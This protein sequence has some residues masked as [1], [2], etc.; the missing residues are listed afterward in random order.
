VFHQSGRTVDGVTFEVSG[1]N[2]LLSVFDGDEPPRVVLP[3]DDEPSG[4]S[5]T[6][7]LHGRW[8]D[9]SGPADLGESDDETEIAAAADD[10]DEF[11]L[12]DDLTEVNDSE[13]ATD[14]IIRPSGGTP[15]GAPPADRD[16]ALPAPRPVATHAPIADRDAA[17]APSP[18]GRAGLY[19][20]GVVLGL[21]GLAALAVAAIGLG[22]IGSAEAPDVLPPPPRPAEAVVTAVVAPPTPPPTEAAAEAPAET[23]Q[24]VQPAPDAPQ[25][26]PPVAVQAPAPVPTPV[27]TPAPAPVAVA[28]TRP[29]ILT[30]ATAIASPTP[31][32]PVPVVAPAPPPATPAAGTVVISG[33]ALEVSLVGSAERHAVPGQV[34][35]GQYAIQATFRDH[36]PMGAGTVTVAEGGTVT[37]TCN[38]LFN[39]CAAK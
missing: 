6:Q 5:V 24:I 36:P 7:I 22:W 38:S 3:D 4:Q 31:P 21:G 20:A 29:P 16:P 10:L 34:P 11:P 27:P 14:P 9:A 12:Q 26:A 18:K 39:R 32:A 28:K 19:L 23:P 35:P 1:K 25:P 33:D 37:V 17:P 30:P 15:L 13:P 2:R 8:D